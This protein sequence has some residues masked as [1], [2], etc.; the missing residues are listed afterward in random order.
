[1]ESTEG[2]PLKKHPLYR[3]YSPANPVLKEEYTVLTMEEHRKIASKEEEETVK[4][5][6]REWV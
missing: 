6:I 1:M 4:E 5:R 2:A 3:L